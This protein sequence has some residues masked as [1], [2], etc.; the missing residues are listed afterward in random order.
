MSELEYQKVAAHALIKNKNG[1]YLVTRRSS[2]DDWQP[3]VWDLPGGSIEFSEN[4][5][6]ALLREI[7]EEVGIKVNV[8]RLIY[9]YSFMSNPQRHQFQLVYECEYVSGDIKLNPEDH[10]E[11]RWLRPEEFKNLKKIAFFESLCDKLF[12]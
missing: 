8:L 11:F 10:D 5:E 1:E 3:G 2:I 9:C 6:D 7:D 12:V 4:P